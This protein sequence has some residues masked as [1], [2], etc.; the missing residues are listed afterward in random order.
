MDTLLTVSSS[1]SG[2]S[3]THLSVPGSQTTGT[4]HSVFNSIVLRHAGH[5]AMPAYFDNIILE[6]IG[7]T[8]PAYFTDWQDL[9]WPGVTDGSIIGLDVDPD[10]DGL[11]NLAEWALH[12]DPKKGAPFVPAMVFDGDFILH[13]YTRRK[14]APG[15]ASFHVEWSDTL[16]TDDWSELDVVT[17]P[18]VSIDAT[19]ESVTSSIPLGTIERRFIRVRI[20]R[21]PGGG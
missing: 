18:P 19:S 6:V 5:S 12:L 21:P 1:S 3:T 17:S 20:S 9:T 10:S 15:E 7:G 14:T 13:T 4:N 16:A 11:T 8:N 2:V